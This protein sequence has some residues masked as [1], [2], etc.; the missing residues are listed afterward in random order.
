[1]CHMCSDY[2]GEW[3]NATL[4]SYCKR[5]NLETLTYPYPTY[6]A[7]KFIGLG[8]LMEK[9]DI[10]IIRDTNSIMDAYQ[11]VSEILLKMSDYLYCCLTWI[12]SV[13]PTISNYEKLTSGS[14]VA[15]TWKEKDSFMQTY[16]S[17]LLDLYVH[18]Y[19]QSTGLRRPRGGGP[20]VLD[21]WVIW[22]SFSGGSGM[23]ISF[24]LL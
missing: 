11:F 3:Y 7:L 18:A 9:S 16:T 12:Y 23:C 5:W 20:R 21:A 10:V 14:C 4:G 8:W 2:H 17:K 22:R 1:M 24:R 13:F 19:F 15:W 6:C